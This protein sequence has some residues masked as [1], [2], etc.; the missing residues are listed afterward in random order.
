VAEPPSSQIVP[1][2]AAGVL[3]CQLSEELLLYL[4]GGSAAVALNA[5][6][7]AVWELCDGRRSLGAIAADL[8]QRFDA[9][10]DEI[11]A[12]VRDAVL[13]LDR[14]RLLVLPARAG[15]R[16]AAP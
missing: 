7:R 14:L 10:A 2:R 6:A 4:P 12:A 3:E 11:P 5:S 16:D 1:R 9:P 8:A 13:E 15:A